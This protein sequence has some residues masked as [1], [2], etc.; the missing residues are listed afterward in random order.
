MGNLIKMDLYRMNKAKSFRVCLILVFVLALAST[1]L[2][3][4][5]TL[6]AKS[7]APDETADFAATVNLS[8]IIG[9]PLSALMIML[10]LLSV[11]SFFFADMEAGYI[12]NIAGQMP[13]KGFSVL[14]RYIAAV[15]HNIA[16]MLTGLAGNLIGTLPLRR[17]IVD[18]AVPESAGI[19]L[20]KLLLL[21][22]I[23]AILLLFVTSFRNKSIGIVLA[24]LLGLPV[25]SLIYLGINTGLEKIFGGEVNI[26]PYM[27]DQILKETKPELI[28]ALLVS[29]VTIG[30]FLP[31]SIR[32]FDK[33]DVK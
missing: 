12:K 5:L 6:L 9:S 15:P 18:G 16:F 24:V 8:E 20:L 30:I 22:C 26:A 2:E 33:K 17:I 31:L 27:P 4:A 29:A 21:H 11:V 14:S 10:A 23:C 7:L 25:M 3:K 19:F 32:V 13:K 1:P 28:R